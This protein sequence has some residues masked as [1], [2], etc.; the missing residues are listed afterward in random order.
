MLGLKQWLAVALTGAVF[1]LGAAPLPGAELKTK[2]EDGTKLS[3]AE[4][5]SAAREGRRT[6][7]GPSREEREKRR[8]QFNKLTP[9]QR[10]AK[11]KEI[12]ERLEKRISE[13]RVRQTNA[14]ITVQES[15]ELE[16]REQILKRFEQPPAQ[17]AEPAAP[18]A[19][20]K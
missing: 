18:P 7:A 16:R 14:T 17:A 20:Q 13:L 12:K 4:R 5:E 10:E 3:A 9:E 11:R 2:G 6:N 15:R 19:R 8:E 1:G